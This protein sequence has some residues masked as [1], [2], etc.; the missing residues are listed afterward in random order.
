[1][2]TETMKIDNCISKIILIPV[3]TVFLFL[4]LLTDILGNVPDSIK[5][6]CNKNY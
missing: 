1:M 6:H 5:L 4:T 3:I 2:A